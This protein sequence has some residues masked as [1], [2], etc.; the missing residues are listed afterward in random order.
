MECQEHKHM[1]VMHV[2]TE[3]K[4]KICDMEFMTAHAPANLICVICSVN[5]DLCEVCG[6]E[7]KN[8]EN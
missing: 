4:C 6:K 1:V 5:H 8:G 7:M 3:S 2:M